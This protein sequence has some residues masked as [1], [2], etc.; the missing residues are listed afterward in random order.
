[1]TDAP[2]ATT[3]RN[4]AH[5]YVRNI[6]VDFMPMK[7]FA[8]NPVILAEGS[9]VA[10]TDVNGRRYFDGISG[11]FCL[12]L[13]HAHPRIVEAATRQLE[14]LAMAA[15]TM[16]T[17]DRSL[18]L[19]ERLLGLL[20]PGRFTHVKWGAGGSEANEQAIKIAR[21]YHRQ[22]GNPRKFKVLSH[23]RGY[24]GATGFA[25]A[26][27]GWPH[28]K[29]AFE[30][31][32]GGFVHLHT[33]DPYRPVWPAPTEALGELYARLVE[34]TI[35]MEG[36][37]TI[38]ALI[39]EPVLMSAGVVVPPG[40]YL[41][42]L[43]ALCDRYDI[44]L[45]FD[46]IITGF[47][48]T[49]RLFASERIDTWADILVLGK[50]ISGGYTP[51]S[52]T[53]LSRRIGESFWGDGEVH[54]QA[55]HTYGGNPVGCAVALAA[56][57]EITEERLWENAEARGRQALARMQAWQARF[58]AIGDVRGAGLLVGFELVRDRRT[59]ER[60]PAE[61]NLGQRIRN[62]ATARGLL[63]RA[64]HWMLALAP[65]L[66]TTEAEMDEMLDRL[67]LAVEEVLGAA[68]T[69]RLVAA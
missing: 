38:A 11:T 36:P 45:I 10:V 53:V 57:A 55:G 69:R 26:A 31:M 15:P 39:T 9:G 5:D 50:G 58:P 32:A 12:S 41:P 65:P 46:E 30:P 66:T 1:M 19:A 48:R 7:W 54:F 27:T 22:S 60:F 56:I 51:L 59:K 18:E 16:A 52:A 61:L 62:A 17:S 35:L 6:M 3:G 67:G 20:P 21:Q 23:Y 34:E 14:R 33:P 28:M 47:G 29:S 13:G 42:R 43:R 63:A 49:G 25:L 44:T 64:S 2:T 8:E 40:D 68:E 24:H 37:E 4:A